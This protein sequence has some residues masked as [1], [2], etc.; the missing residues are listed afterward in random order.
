MDSQ[1]HYQIIYQSKHELYH[2][3]KI[4]ISFSLKL[5]LFSQILPSMWCIGMNFKWSYFFN[6][7]FVNFMPSY[8]H[9]LYNHISLLFK[10]ILTFKIEIKVNIPLTPVWESML[11]HLYFSNPNLPFQCNHLPLELNFHNAIFLPS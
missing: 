11:Q 10:K 2:F 9:G 6:S 1:V 8:K 5:M 4:N 7:N 3:F